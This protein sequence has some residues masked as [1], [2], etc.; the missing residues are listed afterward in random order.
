MK[1]SSI[2]NAMRVL[3]GD[4]VHRDFYSP[5][6]PGQYYV[7]AGLFQFFGNGFMTERLSDVAVR[8]A[9]LTIVY[10]ILRR[11][12]PLLIAL[13]FTAIAGMWLLAIGYYLYPIFPCM[14]LSLIGSY[15]VTRAGKRGAPASAIFGAGS[16]TGLTALFRYDTGFL[17]LIAHL[18]SIAVLIALS[19]PRG[20]RGRRVLTAVM[21]YGVGTA[22]V[23]VP[24]AIV[25]LLISPI[26]SFVADIVDYPTKYYALMRGLPFPDLQSIRA[27]PS[28][29]AVYL[30]L[31]AA[32]CVL[33]ELIRHPAQLIGSAAWRRG[34]DR[35]VAYL[36][37]FG[38]TATMLS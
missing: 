20:G 13:M 33:L 16:L 27:T 18:F 38:S 7:V 30:P 24:A 17:L 12:C 21:A 14:L 3:H 26:G 1:A 6:G 15:L 4:I 31:L 37:V 8:A 28:E 23:F 25:F 35:V 19:E 11:Q 2:S 22:V 32:G 34:G 29:G 9:V 5:Y 36:V 10:F